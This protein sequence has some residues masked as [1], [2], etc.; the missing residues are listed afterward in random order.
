MLQL[1]PRGP[2]GVRAQALDDMGNLVDDFVF[3]SGT[4]AIGERMLHVR[5]AP[6]PAA[7][8]S[9]AIARMIA[10]EVKERFQLWVVFFFSQPQMGL[11][12]IYPR[13]NSWRAPC[14]EINVFVLSAECACGIGYLEWYKALRKGVTFLACP[15]FFPEIL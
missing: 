2:S 3:D 13:V 9:L 15:V 7:T 11:A 6:S 8:S 1:L 10:D 4:D 14:V 5:N 12:L